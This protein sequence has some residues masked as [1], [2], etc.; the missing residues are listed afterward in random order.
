MHYVACLGMGV[1][2]KTTPIDCLVDAGADL[3]SQD[4]E[5]RTPLMAAIMKGSTLDKKKETLIHYC[6]GTLALNIADKDGNNVLHLLASKKESN[7]TKDT[8]K[9]KRFINFFTLHYLSFSFVPMLMQ[10]TPTTMISTQ[11][12]LQTITKTLVC[13]RS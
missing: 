12:T 6:E 3:A 9:V 8:I 5:G 7:F 11:G 4:A 2:G 13:M 10:N 1:S